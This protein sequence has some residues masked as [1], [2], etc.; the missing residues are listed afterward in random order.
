LVHLTDGVE[1]T[2]RRMA[3]ADKYVKDYAIGTECGF[4]RRPPE[5]VRPLLQV[6]ARAAGVS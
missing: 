1:G 6:H 4:G 3:T 5:T 2:R